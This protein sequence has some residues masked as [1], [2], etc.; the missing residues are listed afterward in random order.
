MDGHDAPGRGGP[1]VSADIFWAQTGAMIPQ[2]DDV[3]E[4][5]I[6]SGVDGATIRRTTRPQEMAMALQRS[7]RSFNTT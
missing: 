2:P 7:Y 3:D 1:V 6:S 5:G 4:R